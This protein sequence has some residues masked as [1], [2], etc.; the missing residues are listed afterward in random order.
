[1]IVSDASPLI[2]LAKVG[3]LH[4]LKELFGKV[5]I[6]EEVKREAVDRGKEEYAPDALI[7]EDAL[8]EGWIEVKKISAVKDIQGIH[9]GERNSILLAEKHKCIV[10]I[11]DEDGRE[12]ARAMLL[13]VKGTLYVLKK[14]VEKGNLR[15]QDAISTLNE[16]MSGGFRI[17]AR[18]YSK[19]LDELEKV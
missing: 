10:L 2:N 14:A 5:L 4:L 16:M 15:K 18:I 6:E 17:S 3:K 19:F 11:D 12:V 9:S 8:R 7:I 1:M 13:K